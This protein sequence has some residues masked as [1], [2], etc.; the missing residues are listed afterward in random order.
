MHPICTLKDLHYA[1]LTDASWS[2]DGQM[3]SVSSM[4]GYLSF[5]HFEPGFF[6]ARVSPQSESS[7]AYA[8]GGWNCHRAI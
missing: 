5:I 6:G 1:D 4:D 3:L 7:V 8:V 2:A